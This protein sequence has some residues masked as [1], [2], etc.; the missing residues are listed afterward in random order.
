[1][2][3]GRI[4]LLGLLPLPTRLMLGSDLSVDGKTT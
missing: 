2:K 4:F 1:M 3:H